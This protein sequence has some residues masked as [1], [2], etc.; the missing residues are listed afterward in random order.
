MTQIL[1]RFWTDDS[2]FVA[3]S[4]T[5]LL[6]TILTLGAICGLVT[7]RDTVATEMGDL[8]TALMRMDQS[9]SYAPVV[10]DCGTVAGSVYL[11]RF[12]FCAAGLSDD[13]PPQQ[14]GPLFINPGDDYDSGGTEQ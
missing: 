7:V 12:D 3:S 10:T 4:E 5:V 14:I 6:G 13:D 2:G 8:A 1:R 9:Y 11:D